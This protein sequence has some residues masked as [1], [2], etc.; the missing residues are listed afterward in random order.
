VAPQ[1]VATASGSPKNAFR[2]NIPDCYDAVGVGS[3]CHLDHGGKK[4]GNR[5]RV[6]SLEAF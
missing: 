5:L 3:A 2:T 4:N 1:S 6:R